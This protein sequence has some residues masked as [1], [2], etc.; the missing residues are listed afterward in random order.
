M[1]SRVRIGIAAV[2]LVACM[3]FGGASAAAFVANARLQILAAII[4]LLL[5]F[6][7]GEPPPPRLARLLRWTVC[8]LLAF[9]AIQLVPLPPSVW[10]TLPG[11]APAI[12]AFAAVGL[13]LPWLPL[14][15]TPDRT[16]GSLLAFLPPLAML[17]LVAPPSVGNRPLWPALI[18]AIALV[19]IVLG[20]AQMA[21]GRQSP[22]YFYDFTNWGRTVG[23]FANRNHHATF[24]LMSLP[25]AAMLAML[26]MR[27]PAP[28][29]EKWAK[30]AMLA[31]LFAVIAGAILVN[32]SKAGILLLP[33]LL[34]LC[35]CQIR[36]DLTGRTPKLWLALT[37]AAL[38]AGT[39]I[40]GASGLIAQE[41]LSDGDPSSR[42][43]RAV[44]WQQSWSLAAANLPAGSGLGS[45]VPVYHLSEDPLERPSTYVNHAHNDYLEW[46]LETGVIGLLLLAG[47]LTWFA[48]RSWSAWRDPAASPARAASIAIVALLV[49]SAVDYPIRT[50][51][52]AVLFALCCVLLASPMKDASPVTGPRDV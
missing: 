46:L 45:F 47:F 8:L 43:S 41:Q 32:G 5:L 33:L 36:M 22:L 4:L 40:A 17:F 9:A 51:A 2:F 19:Q 31:S 1:S 30:A 50:A 44:L 35:A 48:L 29:H 28:Q 7:G 34:A 25:F 21:G 6:A 11:H 10:T 49:H 14:S 26:A 38:L 39:A 23:L 16:V 3:I 18:V 20:V 13:P 52:I 27:R 42:T 24:L 15:L 12:E 37:A